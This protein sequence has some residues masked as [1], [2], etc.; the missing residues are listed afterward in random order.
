MKFGGKR[1]E[2]FLDKP[3]AGVRAALVYGPD[4][5]LVWERARKL[6]RTLVGALDDPFQ[7]TALSGE[8]VA[9]APA[10]L[11]DSAAEYPLT[12]GLRLVWVTDGDDS[13]APALRQLIAQPPEGSFTLLVAG[14]LGKNSA[15]RRAVEGASNAAALPCYVEDSASLARLIADTLKDEGVTID[16]DAA[17]L[18]AGNLVGDRQL[19]RR[20]VEKLALYAGSGGHIDLAA[21]AACVG[22]SAS[23]AMDELADAVAGGQPGEADRLLARLL[24]DGKAGVSVV[25]ALQNHFQRLVPAA[26]AVAAGERADAV[27]EAMKPPIFFKRRDAVTRQLRRWSPGELQEALAQLVAAERRLKQSGP[28]EHAVVGQAVL[29]LAARGKRG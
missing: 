20:A 21:A 6:A 7:V 14:D 28:P 13:A 16:R 26:R 17:E 10:L 11:R 25:R 9:E 15:L 5:G 3:E 27:V 4:N 18:A 1:L 22:D 29:S 24:A 19:A 8:A 23:V 2:K 12:G